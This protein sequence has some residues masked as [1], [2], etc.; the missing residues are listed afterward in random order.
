MRD[1][2]KDL[3]KH[4][5]SKA[6]GISYSRLRKYA[7]NQVK[8]L[9]PEEKSSIYHYLLDKANKIKMEVEK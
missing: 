9:T 6:T 7:S 8:N 2:L 1:I 4:S 3:N 5:L